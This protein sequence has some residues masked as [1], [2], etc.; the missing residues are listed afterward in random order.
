MSYR[1]WNPADKHADIILSNGDRTS[2]RATQGYSGLRSTVSHSSG[3]WYA[4]VLIN[5]GA[6]ATYRPYIGIAQDDA[7]F[8]STPGDYNSWVMYSNPSTSAFKKYG[9]FPAAYGSSLVDGDVIGIALDFTAGTLT[10]YVNGVSRGIAFSSISSQSL[11][12]FAYHYYDTDSYTLNLS[13]DTFSYS[14]PSGHEAWSNAYAGEATLTL[15]SPATSD[16]RRFVTASCPTALTISSAA[17]G[18]KLFDYPSAPEDF[19]LEGD[20]PSSMEG[21]VYTGWHIEYELPSVM[22]SYIDVSVLTEASLV[23]N[24]ASVVNGHVYGGATLTDDLPA[25]LQ[26]Y[27]DSVTGP[28]ATLRGSLPTCL[29]GY[30]V[31]DTIQA[32]SARK[33]PTNMAGTMTALM[34]QTLA[35]VS[36]MPTVCAGEVEITYDIGVITLHASLPTV[37]DGTLDLPQAGRF[38]NY[39]L[40]FEKCCSWR[41]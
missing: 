18:S 15:G 11:Y 14:M 1:G 30:A 2:S 9:N 37:I 35:F 27:I 34:G 26:G 22:T 29:D 36:W 28:A 19:V 10:F 21:V 41:C 33:L 16:V 20:L 38:D 5:D 4:E 23:N 3:K 25:L 6:S 40:D 39:E 12:L 24:L 7:S 17:S 31:I 32:S 13:P 8:T